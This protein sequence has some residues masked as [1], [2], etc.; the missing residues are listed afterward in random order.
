MIYIRHYNSKTCRVA[1]CFKTRNRTLHCE[2]LSYSREYLFSQKA[3]GDSISGPA[4]TR[5]ILRLPTHIS[6]GNKKFILPTDTTSIKSSHI[7]RLVYLYMA[8]VQINTSSNESVSRY[9][10]LTIPRDTGSTS[11]PEQGK[12]PRP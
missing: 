1:R 5:I 6:T 8:N 10:R 2:T 12:D 4:Q 9:V 7:R 3:T 11:S